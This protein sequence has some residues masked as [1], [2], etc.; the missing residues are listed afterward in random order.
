M[1]DLMGKNKNAVMFATHLELLDLF[2][3]FIAVF[4]MALI[5]CGI[6]FGFYSKAKEL[7]GAMKS[8]KD[9]MFAEMMIEEHQQK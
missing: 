4:T 8:K 3:N 9:A 5:F 7:K 1:S 6:L 2:I